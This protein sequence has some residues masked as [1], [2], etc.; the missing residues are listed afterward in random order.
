[1]KKTPEQVKTEANT[2]R[3]RAL[4]EERDKDK[5]KP[6]EQKYPDRLFDLH[7]ELP[8]GKHKGKLLEDI[9][10][11]DIGYVTWML[12]NVAN[13]HLSDHAEAIYLTLLDPRRGPRAWEA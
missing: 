13:F 7:D 5:P 10:N 8:F 12:E 2:A 9:F 6:I 3:L 11:D 1:M 4:R